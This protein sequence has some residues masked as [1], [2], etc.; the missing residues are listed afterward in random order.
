MDVPPTWHT[1]KAGRA[2][3]VHYQL[4]TVPQIQLAG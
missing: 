2:G 4:L 1:I 3:Q